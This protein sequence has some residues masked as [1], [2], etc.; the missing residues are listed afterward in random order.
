MYNS[1]ISHVFFWRQVG[2]RF[3][4]FVLCAPVRRIRPAVSETAF[5]AELAGRFSDS[6]TKATS[7]IAS[8][9]GTNI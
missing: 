3:E 9:L 2:A 1:V 5:Y 6:K 7:P 4:Y 8:K